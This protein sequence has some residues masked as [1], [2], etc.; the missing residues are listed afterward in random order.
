MQYRRKPRPPFQEDALA[1]GYPERRTKGWLG[2][3]NLSDLFRL[4][5]LRSRLPPRKPGPRHNGQK[6]DKTESGARGFGLAPSDRRF[7]RLQAW[8]VL[9]RAC[10]PQVLGNPLRSQRPDRFA[11]PA[12]RGQLVHM[13]EPLG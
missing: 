13:F 6:A 9:N 10:K 5:E 3:L 12:G 2:S 1:P 7:R 8:I 11:S 4:E